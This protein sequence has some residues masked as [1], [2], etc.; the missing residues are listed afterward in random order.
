MDARTTAIHQLELQVGVL[1]AEREKYQTLL[2]PLR[3]NL[4]PPEILGEIFTFSV[5]NSRPFSWNHQLNTLCLVCKSWR[6]A[7]LIHPALWATVGWYYIDSPQNFDVGKVK[8][9]LSRS[10]KVKKTLHVM[11]RHEADD[12]SL[13]PLSPHDLS[14][15]LFLDG[16]PLDTLSLACTHAEC[17]EAIFDEVRFGPAKKPSCNAIHSLTLGMERAS[18]ESFGRVCGILHR[19]PTVRTLSLALPQFHGYF[20][21]HGE[22]PGPLPFGNL[23]GLTLVCD[24]SVSLVLDILENCTNLETLILETEGCA[25]EYAP[26]FPRDKPILVLPRLRTLQ[27]KEVVLSSKDTDILR[28]LRL[29]SLH[30]LDI[31]FYT[32]DRDEPHDYNLPNI[33]SDII[34]LVTGGANRATSL[35]HLRLESLAITSQGLNFILSALPTLTQLTLDKLQSDSRLFRHA[36]TFGTKLL[37]GLKTL[38][39]HEAS[40]LFTFKYFDVYAFLSRRKHGVTAQESLDYL[41]EAEL[42]ISKANSTAPWKDGLDYRYYH[43]SEIAK[44]ATGKS[45][46]KDV[47]GRDPSDFLLRVLG[48]RRRSS[49]HLSARDA[50]TNKRITSLSTTTMMDQD[51]LS[52]L[53]TGN[54][55]LNPLELVFVK[56]EIEARSTTIHQLELQLGVLKAEREIHQLELQ[57]G[58]LKAER[59]MYQRLL[60]PLRRNLLPL[61]ILGEIFSISVSTSTSLSWDRQLN[62]LCRVC[63]AWRDAALAMPALWAHVEEIYVDVPKKL[64]IARVREWLKRSGSVKKTLHINGLHARRNPTTCPL[65][66]QHALPDLLMDGPPLDKLSLTC[67]YAECIEIII[68]Q[69]KLKAAK[70]RLCDSIRSVHLGMSRT[71]RDMSFGAIWAILDLIPTIHAFSLELSPYHFDWEVPRNL[72]QSNLTS[73]TIACDWPI[74]LLLDILRNCAGIE[75][76]TLDHQKTPRRGLPVNPQLEVL[77]PKLKTLQMR[78]LVALASSD[79]T[80]FRHLRLPSLHTL[81]IIFVPGPGTALDPDMTGVRQHIVALVSGGPN[82][83]TNLQRLRF[84]S[85]TI[86]P[87]GLHLIL[88]SLPMLAHLTLDNIR[89]KSLFFRVACGFP[90]AKLLPRLRSLRILN[91]SE[92]V[93]FDYNDVCAFLAHR[94]Y[95]AT[96]E[97][98]DLLEEVRDGREGYE[99]QHCPDFFL[100]DYTHRIRLQF[101]VSS[102]MAGPGK[103]A[104]PYNSYAKASATLSSPASEKRV[105]NGRMSGN[106]LK[107]LVSSQHPGFNSERNPTSRVLSAGALMSRNILRHRSIP[108][109]QLFRVQGEVAGGKQLDA[110][111]VHGG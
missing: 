40:E 52:H 100:I 70:G 65:S 49:C 19:I 98:P 35:Q 66:L 81:D 101:E 63:R 13:C 30:T 5:S 88:Y 26:A 29:P 71:K 75:S 87:Q 95:A 72:S 39:I 42:T 12:N 15:K 92:L 76:L 8:A 67:A 50:R 103:S 10:G 43:A 78:R 59:E 17:L 38:R 84:E 41:E 99:G 18:A 64:H 1:K 53:F 31:I 56:H 83:A 7:A 9:W 94:K 22:L 89:S 45:A 11:G 97:S 61:E 37:P 91:P 68:Q 57:L 44:E 14:G 51:R 27:L 48:R 74:L 4:L 28:Y 55:T 20:T 69:M 107:G 16:P 25:R 2:S 54:V 32:L 109:E 77:L 108:L 111:L 93:K 79:T 23:S 106:H 62:T 82:R 85:V 34:S 96:E 46:H 102:K 60:S 110:F 80:I 86:S 73:L 104:G 47:A 6:A 33:G 58:I 105:L 3:R 21:Y 36:H 90:P 24:W